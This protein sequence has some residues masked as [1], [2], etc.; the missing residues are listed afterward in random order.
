MPTQISKRR[1]TQ[2]RSFLL[3]ELLISLA[4][5]ALC[6]FPLIKPHAAMRKGQLDHLI[7]MQLEQVNQAAFCT[8]KKMLYENR[9]PAWKQ[10]QKETRGTLEKTFYIY[11]GKKSAI[12]ITCVYKT[13]RLDSTTKK[14]TSTKALVI[15][16]QLIFTM[17]Q[18]KERTF[19]H[20]LYLEQRPGE[21]V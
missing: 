4:L 8:F 17:P 3:F 14:K 20:T 5:I 9:G 10:L 12:P 7:E 13:E 16:V 18:H 6:L 11:T 2:K 19:S 21:S 1:T 15:D